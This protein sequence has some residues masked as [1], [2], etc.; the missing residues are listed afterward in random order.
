[1]RTLPTLCRHSR[2]Q[3]WIVPGLLLLSG[4]NLQAHLVTT[5][6]GPFYDGL[7][8]FFLTPEDWL[9]AIAL[10]LLGGL[11]GPGAG[12][13]VLCLL[14]AV[15]LVASLISPTTG[16]LA[17]GHVAP[18][19]L[20]GLGALVASGL[21]LSLRIITLITLCAGG[22]HGWQNGLSLNAS[23]EFSIVL[24]GIGLACFVLTALAAGLAVKAAGGWQRIAVRVAGSWIAA[25]GLLMLGW[26]LRK[27]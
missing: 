8:H 4:S 23:S 25:T 20:V 18:V 14:P 10:A 24:L 7:G 3:P 17:P 2:P 5:G 27:G 16:A 19:L 21:R 26:A 9:M 11:Q 6:L 15:W 12:R 22:F 1:M 13:R